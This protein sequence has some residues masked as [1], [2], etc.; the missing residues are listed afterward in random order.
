MN[1]G[2]LSDGLMSYQDTHWLGMS[3]TPQQKCSWYVLQPS[4][5]GI[6]Y[7]CMV[8]QLL[9]GFWSNIQFMI[10]IHK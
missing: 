7:V 2:S 4:R 6:I 5:L 9:T 3:L 10:N 8:D 1:G